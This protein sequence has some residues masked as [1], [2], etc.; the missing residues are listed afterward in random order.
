MA[1]VA[2]GRKLVVIA[3]HMLKHSE[4]HRY[5]QPKETEVKLARLRVKAIGRRHKPGP[6]KGIKCQ[7]KLTGGSHT[8]KPLAKREL[9]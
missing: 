2:T 9:Y 1:V 8:V 5:A 6:A 7:A 3:W 4:P